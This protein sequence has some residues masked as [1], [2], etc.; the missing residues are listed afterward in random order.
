MIDRCEIQE[1]NFFD[2]VPGGGDCYLLANIVHDWDDERSVTILR[3]CQ[4]A[5]PSHAKILLIERAIFA[6][7]VKSLPT[8]LADISMMVLTGGKER[9][10]DEY[11]GLLAQ[12]GLELR[13]TIPV[14][15]PYVI[16]EGAQ[17]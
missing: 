10:N 2:S 13:R 1:G 14:L 9:T 17:S 11:A 6:D 5:M 7:Q 16:F 12:A 3:N 15:P 4:R 8:L